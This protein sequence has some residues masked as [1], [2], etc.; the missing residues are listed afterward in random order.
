MM[1]VCLALLVLAALGGCSNI[2]EDVRETA[3]NVLTLQSGTISELK[4]LRNTGPFTTYDLP[5]DELLSVVEDAAR[6]ARGEGDHPVRAIFVSERR[7]EVVAKERGAEDA[8]DDGYEKPFRSAMVATVHPILGEPTK[9]RLEIHAMQRGPFHKGRVQWE[10]DMP[11]W[12][13]A[14]IAERANP[15]PRIRPIR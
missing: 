3:V 6:K 8:A 13:D 15:P 10:R 4:D 11:G 7:G 14:V 2:D 5:P 1:R 12:I 9:S